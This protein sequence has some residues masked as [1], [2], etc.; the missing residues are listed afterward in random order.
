[1][2]VLIGEELPLNEL[3]AAFDTLPAMRRMERWALQAV[4][5]DARRARRDIA[6]HA[7]LATPECG[8]DEALVRFLTGHDEEMPPPRRL[9]A[10]ALAR[11]LDRHG[12]PRAGGPPAALAGGVAQSSATTSLRTH[13]TLRAA[14][15]AAAVH[16]TRFQDR[17]TGRS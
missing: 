6:E 14:C 2:F 1:M 5:E 11:G 12:R 10:H 3:E 13:R 15:R 8:P 4:R 17:Q 16:T 7:L 9:H